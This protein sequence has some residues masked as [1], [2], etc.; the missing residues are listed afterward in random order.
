[1]AVALSN[2]VRCPRC[3]APLQGLDKRP[4]CTN[5]DCRYAALGFPMAGDQPVLID[6]EHS[7]FDRPEGDAMPSVIP[8]DKGLRG[9]MWEIL[10]GSN[11]TSFENSRTMLRAM[12]ACTADPV[13]LIIGGGVIGAG[14][15]VFLRDPSVQIIATD[16]YA[17]PNT[18]LVTDA[19]HLPFDDA[20]FDGVWI[21]AV[22]EHVL[23]PQTVVNEIWRVLKPSGQV[24]AETPFMQQVHE[25]AYDFSRFT[26]SGHRWLCRH[27]ERSTPAS[28]AASARGMR[29]RGHSAISCEASSATRSPPPSRFHS[30]RCAL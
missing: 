2:I 24:Y 9:R 22:L 3:R 14:V 5:P 1:M 8:R 28:I 15:D 13:L 10:D 25:R 20:V 19:H 23:E 18:Q 7:I 4:L 21:T 29:W 17:S 6:F 30:S 27:F 16:V 12:K 11:P 26:A